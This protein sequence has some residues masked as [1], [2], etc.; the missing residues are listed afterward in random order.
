[1]RVVADSHAI[2]WFTQRSTHL[3]ER[4]A[5]ALRDA[6]RSE[7]IT[8]SVATFVDLW[9]VT[10]SAAVARRGSEVLDPGSELVRREVGTH[11]RMVPRCERREPARWS[12]MS[13]RYLA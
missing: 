3:S 12:A 1:L 2:V 6:A 9:Y 4:A 8:V 7:G 5:G 11:P 13:W 10:P